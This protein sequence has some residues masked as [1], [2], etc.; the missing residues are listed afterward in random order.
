MSPFVNVDFRN[1]APGVV[2]GWFG[3][4]PFLVVRTALCEGL[5]VRLSEVYRLK[6]SGGDIQA[7]SLVIDCQVAI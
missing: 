6:R 3:I 2:W 7:L 5:S 1:A 4:T